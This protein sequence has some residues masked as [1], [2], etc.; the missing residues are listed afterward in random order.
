MC[1]QHSTLFTRGTSS[2]G[3]YFLH[4]PPGPCV[5]LGILLSAGF[6]RGGG[7]FKTS[8]IQAAATTFSNSSC[9]AALCV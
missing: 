3:G 4:F 2:D 7:V 6:M 5:D 1:L 9:G 8:V